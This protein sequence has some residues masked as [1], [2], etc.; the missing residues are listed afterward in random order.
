MTADL[1]ALTE[2]LDRIEAL[3]P[4]LIAALPK[5]RDARRR[6][7]AAEHRDRPADVPPVREAGPLL[8]NPLTYANCLLSVD[9]QD[10]AA[11]VL[12]GRLQKFQKR[13]GELLEPW[14]GVPRP[15]Y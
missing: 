6:L 2:L 5:R 13:Y 4:T 15:G 1:R 8:G 7:G 10:E 14:S 12:Q 3:N 11:Q 9:A